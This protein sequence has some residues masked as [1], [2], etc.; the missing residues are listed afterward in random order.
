MTSSVIGLTGYAQAGKDT[1]GSILVERGYKRLSFA[2]NVREAIWRLN[3]MVPRRVFSDYNDDYDVWHTAQEWVELWGWERVKVD[4]PEM[5]RLL[6]VMGTEVGREMFGEESWVEMVARQVSQH[7]KVV[8]TDVRFPNEAAF[9]RSVGGRV[10]RIERL[11]NRPVNQHASE[12]LDF[13]VDM[14]IPNNGTIEDLAKDI[15]EL[16]STEWSSQ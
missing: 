7:E 11:G 1:V 5:R 9:V 10:I 15:I 16:D 14:V 2:D 8:I 12:K 4:L 3:P 6:Q 13:R